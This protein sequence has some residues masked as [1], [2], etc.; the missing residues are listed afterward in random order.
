MN[1]M[2]WFGRGQLVRGD[3]DGAISTLTQV[4][5]GTPRF[6]DAYRTRAEAFREAGQDDAAEEDIAKLRELT[7]TK[8]GFAKQ[9]AAGQV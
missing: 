2:Y 4:I 3:F 7:R 6:A 9:E 8:G 5:E 1:R